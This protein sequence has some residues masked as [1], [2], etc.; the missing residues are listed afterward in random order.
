MK[1]RFTQA[2]L[3]E[4]L[5]ENHYPQQFISEDEGGITERTYPGE[6]VGGKGSY[7]ELF[8]QN[9][10][11][12]YGDLYLQHLSEIFFES[13]METVEMHFALAGYSS[14]EDRDS[15][16]DFAFSPNEH[17]IVYTS[18]FKGRA[19]MVGNKNLKMFEVN[20]LPG[21]FKRFLPE[22]EKTIRFFLKSM[23]QQANCQMRDQNF[24][25][26]RQMHHL[27][28]EMM[29]CNRKGLFRRLFLE[30][31]VTE[32]LLLQLEQMLAHQ[33]PDALKINKQELERMHAVRKYLMQNLDTPVTL[34]HLAHHFGTN[35]YALK[36]GFKSVFG[37]TVFNFL[38][39]MRM[40][41]A[42]QLLLSGELSIGQVSDQIGYKNPQHFSTAFKRQFGYS[43]SK[44][45]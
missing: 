36:V 13:E 42:K 6:L 21:F 26:T 22:D 24:P 45:R 31:K 32:L 8:M 7:H 1:V 2:D 25:I 18:H 30:A 10:H 35:E 11:I 34:A 40:E 39:G 44:L 14:A 28:Q 4:I 20:L 15:K 17:N 43:P 27:I 33:T 29:H 12:G 19:F 3:Q 41:Q 23:D 16:I 5:L 38:Q 37:T 9:I